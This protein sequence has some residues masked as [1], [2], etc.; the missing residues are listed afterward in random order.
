MA[1]AITA[2]L[3]AM[4]QPA[5]AAGR[6]PG[7][8]GRQNNQTA[9]APRTE[10]EIA[11]SNARALLS[12]LQTSLAQVDAYLPERSLAL[13]QKLTQMGMGDDQR[14]AFGQ[15]ANLMQRGTSAEFDG[16]GGRRSSGNA[17]Q[18]L[19]AGRDDGSRRR[20]HR[21]RARDS[22]IT[23]REPRATIYSGLSISD[24]RP[25]LHLRTKW[26]RYARRWRAQ[27]P[28]MSG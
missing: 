8:R 5:G 20:Q 16:C 19:S 7:F 23:S 13:R 22:R 15:M 26:I 28:R 10:A 4:P 25:G 1:A 3:R 27:S 18:T 24:L 2:S 21:S 17:E 11:Q 12:G 14:T 6:G 9:N